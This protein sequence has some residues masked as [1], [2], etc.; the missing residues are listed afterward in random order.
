MCFYGNERISLLCHLWVFEFCRRLSEMSLM[1]LW[2]LIITLFSNFYFAPF[3]QVIWVSFVLVTIR[4]LSDHT[5]VYYI[6]WRV[7]FQKDQ[8]ILPMQVLSFS[9]EHLNQKKWSWLSQCLTCYNRSLHSN[10]INLT[11]VILIL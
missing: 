10:N 4:I 9:T 2:H 7:F 1:L 8:I 5:F 11:K 6:G 3:Y